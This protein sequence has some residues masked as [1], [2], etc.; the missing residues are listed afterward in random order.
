MLGNLIAA[1]SAFV[2]ALVIALIRDHT[3]LSNIETL[4]GNHLMHRMEDIEN[5]LER[6]EHLLMG[7]K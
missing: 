1:L 5:R 4:V 3:K 2:L 7:R 6:I